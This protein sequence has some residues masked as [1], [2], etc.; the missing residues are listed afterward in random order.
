[1][2][3]VVRTEQAGRSPSLPVGQ[4]EVVNGGAR[5]DVEVERQAVADEG[6]T[7]RVV[8][9]WYHHHQHLLPGRRRLPDWYA[10]YVPVPLSQH[11]TV[12]SPTMSWA[13]V[14]PVRTASTRTGRGNNYCRTGS[15]QWQRRR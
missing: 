6:S 5:G 3:T 15:R 12:A 11:G 7:G 2:V 1:L 4:E 9:G 10:D 8:V 14:V 13:T